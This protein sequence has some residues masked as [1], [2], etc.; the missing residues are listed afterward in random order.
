LSEVA[1]RIPVRDAA[2]ERRELW[3]REEERR[4]VQHQER[5]ARGERHAGY[6]VYWLYLMS[7]FTVGITALVGLLM[8]A[9]RIR[10][11]EP[12][13]A[14]HF[15]FQVKTFWGSLL[16]ALTGGAWAAIG[17]I[18]AAAGEGGGVDLALAGGGLAALS[19]MGFFVASLFGLTRLTSREPVGRLEQL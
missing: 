7:P 17:G 3:R 12:V 18:G 19:W 15:R 9:D 1:C 6:A 16:G 10:E 11:A 5:R 13:N 8:A 4:L 2:A 14:T